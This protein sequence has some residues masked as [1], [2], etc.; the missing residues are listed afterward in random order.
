MAS[1]YSKLGLVA[2]VLGLVF[3]VPALAGEIVDYTNVDRSYVPS[4]SHNHPDPGANWN[5]IS[6]LSPELDLT[7]TF[8]YKLNPDKFAQHDHS[9]LPTAGSNNEMDNSDLMIICANELSTYRDCRVP[10]GG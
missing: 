7:D 6:A 2:L 8:E 4:A 10:F 5:A 9:N 1:K 3:S